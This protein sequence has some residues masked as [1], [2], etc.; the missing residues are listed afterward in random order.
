MANQIHICSIIYYVNID[1]DVHSPHETNKQKNSE[2]H[3][4]YTLILHKMYTF[5]KQKEKQMEN[6]ERK[7][8]KNIII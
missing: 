6:R 2:A 7:K 5:I 4:L 8:S 3:V 1:I